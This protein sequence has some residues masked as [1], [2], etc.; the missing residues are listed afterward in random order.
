MTQ[1]EN[2]D[3]LECVIEYLEKAKENIIREPDKCLIYI[4]NSMREIKRYR[5]RS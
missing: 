2:S 5:D 4:E 3:R 1:S